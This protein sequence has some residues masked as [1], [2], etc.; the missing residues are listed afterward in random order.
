MKIFLRFSLPAALLLVLDEPLQPQL[1]LELAASGKDGQRRRQH[2]RDGVG[3]VC[4]GRDLR[5]VRRHDVEVDVVVVVVV[6]VLVVVD[7]GCNS[8]FCVMLI[9]T[10]FRLFI[11]LPSH[12]PLPD[13]FNRLYTSHYY[14]KQC[15]VDLYQLRIKISRE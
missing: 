12:L 13:G 11:L 4:V 14:F 5:V 2:D 15:A 3:V 7:V 10:I 6:V 8:N 9:Y 1:S